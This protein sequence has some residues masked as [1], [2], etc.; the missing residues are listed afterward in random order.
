M[1]SPQEKEETI[2]SKTSVQEAEEMNVLKGKSL[3]YLSI[4]FVIVAL[5]C[6]SGYLAIHY[7]IQGT[8]VIQYIIL[9]LLGLVLLTIFAFLSKIP[10]LN[11]STGLLTFN[12]IMVCL[13]LGIVFSFILEFSKMIFVGIVFLVLILLFLSV[14]LI[15]VKTKG[16]AKYGKYF[17]FLS[18]L[19][20]T[21]LAGAS[22]AFVQWG[23]KDGSFNEPVL[24]IIYFGFSF[25]FFLFNV[26][27]VS[28]GLVSE[29]QYAK[30]IGLTEK[31]CALYGA[32]GAVDSLADLVSM[33]GH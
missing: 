12:L 14:G 32:F 17:F 31:G 23:L 19:G 9:S 26:L 1:E 16:K 15:E 8:R 21:I 6:F 24:Y 11:Q 27:A 18:L 13:S 30:K 25:A 33:V 28:L 10:K 7:L 5:F 4:G 22:Y 2:V 3:I 20:L 29:I